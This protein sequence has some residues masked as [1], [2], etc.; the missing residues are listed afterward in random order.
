LLGEAKMKQLSRLHL[1]FI[2]YFIIKII[3]DVTAGSHIPGE[4]TNYLNISPKTLYTL[5]IGINVFLFLIGLL[6]FYFLL[7]KRNWARI[8]LLIIGWLA[9]LDFF[10]GLL[11]SSKSAELLAYIDRT[12]NWNAIILIDRVTDFVGFI[13]WGGA[14]FILQFY[15]DVKK[16]FLLQSKDKGLSNIQH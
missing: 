4:A 2:I 16:I 7:E 3:I 12:T 11:F 9:V 13:F 14:I 10:S 15:T 1:F 8:V 5:G 6:L